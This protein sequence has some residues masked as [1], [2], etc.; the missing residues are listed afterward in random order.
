ME[1]GNGDSQLS[2]RLVWEMIEI[3]EADSRLHSQ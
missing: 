2:E 3:Y 1:V